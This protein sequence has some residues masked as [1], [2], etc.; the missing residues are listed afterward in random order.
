MLLTLLV[1]LLGKLFYP[2]EGSSKLLRHIGKALTDHTATHPTPNP[3]QTNLY[4]SFCS[5]K[6]AEFLFTAS[7]CPSTVHGSS[8]LS[9]L[10][11]HHLLPPTV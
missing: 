10:P 6:D 5:R 8:P 1:G 3:H 7:H 4:T 11:P 2:E 9:A